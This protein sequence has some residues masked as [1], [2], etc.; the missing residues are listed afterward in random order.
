[1]SYILR[2]DEPSRTLRLIW[3]QPSPT[4][5]DPI[6]PSL[7]R[8]KQPPH[9]TIISSRRSCTRGRKRSNSGNVLLI[10]LIY[11]GTPPRVVSAVLWMS[12]GVQNRRKRWWAMCDHECPEWKRRR[13][14]IIIINL[15]HNLLQIYSLSRFPIIFL[16]HFIIYFVLWWSS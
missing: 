15:A 10:S 12:C 1:M 8:T 3:S 7:P 16:S 6:I 2:E 11:S 5:Y 9:I 4:I 14:P 13:K